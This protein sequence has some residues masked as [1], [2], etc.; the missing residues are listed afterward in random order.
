VT[1]MGGIVSSVGGMQS[2]AMQGLDSFAAAAVHS[3]GVRAESRRV[4]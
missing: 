3:N 1:D 2:R 4:A